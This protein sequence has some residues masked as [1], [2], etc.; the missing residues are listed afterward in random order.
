MCNG[1][2]NIFCILSVCLILHDYGTN[3]RVTLKFLG[4]VSFSGVF[5]TWSNI[6]DGAFFEN[7]EWLK[8]VTY[9]RKMFHL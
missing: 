1:F 8:A 6:S 2:I 4:E 7:R 9:F 5:R 3:E